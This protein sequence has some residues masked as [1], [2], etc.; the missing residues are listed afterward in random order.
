MIGRK[1]AFSFSPTHRTVEP[2]I[3]WTSQSSG[4]LIFYP[5]L[6]RLN[7]LLSQVSTRRLYSCC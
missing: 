1:G 3:G 6:W 7:A 5:L 2:L 4:L